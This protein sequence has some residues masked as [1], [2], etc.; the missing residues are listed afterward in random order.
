VAGDLYDRAV[1]WLRENG[2]AQSEEDGALTTA[3]LTESLPMFGHC[4]GLSNTE[5]PWIAE[6]EPTVLKENMVVSIEAQLGT[7]GVGTAGF[8]QNLVVRADGAEV[9]TA[10]CPSRWWD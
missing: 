4:M 5:T 6:G 9:L 10:G 3:R 1:R 2:F 7:P 8:E